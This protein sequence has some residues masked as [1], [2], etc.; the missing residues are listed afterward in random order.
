MK[1]LL[2]RIEK[3]DYRGTLEEYLQEGGY[4][5]L[6]KTLEM[7]PSGVIAEVKRS[8]LVGRGGAGFP[9]GLKWELTAKVP[10]S[11]K[12]V[13]CNADEGEPGTFKD[14][15]IMERDPHLL[16]EGMMICGY[17]IGA[18]Q[19]YIYVRGEYTESYRRL[20]AAIQ[21][22]RERHLLGEKIQGTDFSFDIYLYKGAGA[23]VCGEETALLDSL[24]GKR[25]E[26]RL[27]PPYPATSGFRGKPTV[28]NNVET[29]SC[30]P[31]IILNGGEWYSKIGSEG[32]PGT[33]LY[34]LSG[35]VR[36][37]G[38][39]ELP[40]DVTLEEL[41]SEYGRGVEGGAKAALTGG[42]SGGLLTPEQF[43]VTLDYKSMLKAGTGLGSGAIIML[44]QRR[45]MVDVALRCLEFFEHESCGK[46]A[47][48]REGTKRARELLQKI[49][50][51]NGDS[52]SLEL[53][54]ELQRVMYDTCIC[55]LG[56]SALNVTKACIER[57]KG[58]FEE[59]LRGRCV[60]GVCGHD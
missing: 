41:V 43:K 13:V 44:N 23:Y 40:T 20:E 10:D 56:Q 46:C 18:R 22:A 29:L 30:I 5:A 38:V 35:D 37:P 32:S 9:T 31:A 51:G 53:L 52:A 1:I 57:F 60:V 17:A 14:R 47:P 34:C 33:K 12:Y 48:C 15:I 2:K 7:E 3:K 16:L 26:A 28:V 49:R 42:I 36:N 8:G 19:G 21:E 4:E 11:P 39:Y 27:R 45:C 50:R 59:H 6:R 55:G 54:L 25:G 58:E 24:E